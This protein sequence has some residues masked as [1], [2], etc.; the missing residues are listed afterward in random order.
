MTEDNWIRWREKYPDKAG[1]YNVVLRKGLESW[2]AWWN[3]INR[4]FEEAVPEF[5]ERGVDVEYWQPLP[6]PPKSTP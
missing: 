2:V 5:I 1:I 4:R 6:S 3:P